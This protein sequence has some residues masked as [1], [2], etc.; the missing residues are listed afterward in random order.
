MSGPRALDDSCPLGQIAYSGFADVPAGSTH[1]SAVDCVVHWQITNGRTAGSYDPLT[2]VTRAQMAS[3]IARLIDQ[4]SGYLPGAGGYDYFNDDNGTIHELNINRL[5]AA[6]IVGGKSPSTYDPSGYVTRAQMAAFLTRA[7]D[8]RAMQH[9]ANELYARDDFFADDETSPLQDE[10][11]KAATA[12]FTG[13]YDDGTY[14]PG[15]QV[16]RDQ[17]A[18]FLARVLDLAVEQGMTSLPPAPAPA[19]APEPA[20]EPDPGPVGPSNPGDSVNCGDFAT[21][22]E[23]QDWFETYYADYG[24]VARLDG[25]NDMV[26]C[27]SRPGAP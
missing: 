2:P 26:A 27:E 10:I 6:G 8:Y 18:S 19:P 7:Y 1:A 23:A 21:W 3:F 11:N 12:G 20:P 4:A 24:D 22:R 15:G 25:D 9:G 16:R 13:G 5:A 14:R 17:M